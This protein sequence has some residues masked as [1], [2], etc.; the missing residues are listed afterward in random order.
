[1]LHPTP[2]FKGLTTL[3]LLLLITALTPAIQAIQMKA[4]RQPTPNPLDYLDLQATGLYASAGSVPPTE[5]CGA[6]L[7]GGGLAFPN[8]RFTRQLAGEIECRTVRLVFKGLPVGMAFTVVAVE[9]EGYAKV[10]DGG[11]LEGAGVRVGYFPASTSNSTA[12]E[13]DEAVDMDLARKY[14]GVYGG[15]FNLTMNVFPGTDSP[16]TTRGRTSCATAEEQPEME[17][18]FWLSSSH[19]RVDG[20]DGYMYRSTVSDAFELLNSEWPGGLEIGVPY[21]LKW[22]DN[23]G[24]VTIKLFQFHDS[25]VLSDDP[26]LVIVEGYQGEEYTWTPPTTLRVNMNYELHLNDGMSTI[27]YLTYVDARAEATPSSGSS[28]VQTSSATTSTGTESGREPAPT[29]PTAGPADTTAP[30]DSAASSAGLSTA[31]TAA[32]ATLSA[33]IVVG[34][35]GLV[36]YCTVVQRRK[37]RNAETDGGAVGGDVPADAV[38]IYTEG[39]DTPGMKAGEMH[40]DGR[41]ELPTGV[42][43]D[44]AAELSAEGRHLK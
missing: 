31:A 12:P 25:L 19:S 30:S 34:L 14:S 20:D 41:A 10:G 16:R 38:E 22:S 7:V 29:T 28:P 4:P 26:V 8:A 17:V 33:V 1:M 39:T 43:W 44:R 9:V 42:L 23:L 3:A 24:P 35:L 40:G 36:A 6:A 2:S 13:T 11:F 37:R 18:S 21:T 15:V 5:P 32:I 27:D